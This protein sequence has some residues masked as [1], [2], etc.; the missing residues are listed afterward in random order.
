VRAR[1]LVD[2]CSACAVRAVVSTWRADKGRVLVD[3]GGACDVRA[4]GSTWR[5]DKGAQVLVD[6]GVLVM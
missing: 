4:V 3:K 6:E 5:A 2:E 1:V